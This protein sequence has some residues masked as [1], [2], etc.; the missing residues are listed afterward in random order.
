MRTN[1][2]GDKKSS[3]E[4]KTTNRRSVLAS[5]G[6][7]GTA[8]L[9]G[10]AV[11]I[12]TARADSSWSKE[13]LDGDDTTEL[14]VTDTD[15]PGETVLITAG[16]Q[17]GEMAGVYTAENIAAQDMDAGRLYVIPRVNMWALRRNSYVG[18]EGNFDRLFPP[19][20][21]PE[22]ELAREVWDFVESIDPDTVIDLHSSGG[23]YERSGGVGQAIFRSHGDRAAQRAAGAVRETNSMFGLPKSREFRQVPMSYGDAGPSDLFT[24]KT[25]LDPPVSADSYLCEVWRG[26][27]MP[28]RVGFLEH[29]TRELLDEADILDIP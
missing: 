2:P 27:S 1:Q 23:I 28:N 3:G 24:E 19:Y 29:L 9:G 5:I 21:T 10:A 18:E 7:A 6:G 26:F 8:L 15:Q 13:I 17:G 12:G 16:T 14:H 22:S 4:Q 20:D 25:A 11:S